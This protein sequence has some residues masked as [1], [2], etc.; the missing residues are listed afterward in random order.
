MSTSL[1]IGGHK[2][3]PD[4]GLTAQVNTNKT[5]ITALQNLIAVKTVT[6]Y[7]VN[8][9]VVPANANNKVSV[10]RS[11]NTVSITIDLHAGG[12]KLPANNAAAI[13]VSGLPRVN[14]LQGTIIEGHCFV[15]QV[16]TRDYRIWMSGTNLTMIQGTNAQVNAQVY[17]S[18][19]YLTN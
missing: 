18:I 13:L 1:N 5:N 6:G 14:T 8:R 4:S 15:P 7:T 17:G 3:L 16:A 10:T 19:T 12:V 9:A 11:G 2:V